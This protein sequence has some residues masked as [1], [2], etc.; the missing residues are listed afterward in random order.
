MKVRVLC[1]EGQGRFVENDY[2]C[3][4]QFDDGIIVQAVMTGVC[5]SDVAMMQGDFGPLPLHMQG[6]EGLGQV[7]AVGKN[8]FTDIKEGDYVATRGEPAYADRY[9][10][11]EGE[12]VRVPEAHPRYIIEPV[13]CGI[14]VVL[15]DL[16]EIQGRSYAADNPKLLI[17]GSG[18][19]AYVAYKTLKNL[20][21]DMTIDVVGNSNRDIWQEENVNLI[22][23]PNTD[24]EVIINLK[25]EH[26]WLTTPG[27]IRENGCLV[28]AVARSISKKESENLLWQAVTTV[29]P[30][31][32]KSLFLECMELAVE[33]IN[34]GK[35]NVDNFWTKGYN[36]DTNWQ[37][38]FEDSSNRPEHYS[39][40]Y[41]YWTNNGN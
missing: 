34:T 23:E 6:H 5:T 31:P 2:D 29:R 25:E 11:R 27:I 18:F 36:R 7:I 16:T 9:P 13:A 12:Y 41:I 21:I 22:S 39:R 17:I 26:T 32:R 8:I 14:N 24:Y 15:G 40:A 20:D 1:T 3:P 37:Q 28:D 33:W 10:V 35:L 30:S 19:L 38:A 4:D